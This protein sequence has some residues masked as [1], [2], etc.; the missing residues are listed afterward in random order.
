MKNDDFGKIAITNGTSV[1]SKEETS[2]T[3]TKR[4]ERKCPTCSSALSYSRRWDC[5]N[6]E[7]LGVCCSKCGGKKTIETRR[8]RNNLY[9]YSKSQ[10]YKD[11]MSKLHSGTNNPFYGKRHT[12]SA[13]DFFR[14]HSKNTIRTKTWKDNISTAHRGRPKSKEWR[15]NLAKAMRIYLANYYGGCNFNKTACKCF[16][17]L[18]KWNGWNGKHAMNG[19]EFLVKELGYWVD[20]YEPLENIVIEWDEPYHHFDR[21][22]NLKPRDVER[23][24]EIKNALQC[25]F[26]RYNQRTNELKEW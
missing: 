6:A 8:K 7:K 24:N 21:D 9:G 17:W 11:H 2:P 13:I 26:F 25:R 22:G 10:E 3:I 20:Y 14:I 18:N 19:G 23:M 12:Q 5:N 15:K 16:D 1:K 4:W